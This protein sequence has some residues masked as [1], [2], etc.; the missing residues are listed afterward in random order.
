M[1]C[2]RCGTENLEGAAYCNS[3]RAA[4]SD[5]PGRTAPGPGHA[6]VWIA[7][8]GVAAL[9]VVLFSGGGGGGGGGTP[10]SPAPSGQPLTKVEKAAVR[11]AE[12]FVRKNYPDLLKGQRSVSTA[13]FA[14]RPVT[15]VAYAGSM[16]VRTS[17]GALD[18]IPRVVIVT[19]DSRTGVATYNVS[20]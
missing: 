13:E 19:V 7:I 14:G 16:K 5:A 18:T 1:K 4:L 12:A 6:G 3:C 10:A 20:D 15:S 17:S 11:T 8:A 9:I 2:R